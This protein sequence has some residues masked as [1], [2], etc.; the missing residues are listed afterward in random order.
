MIRQLSII[1]L[2]A[3]F[4]DIAPGYRIRKLT[5][6]ELSDKVSQMVGQTRDW[7]QGLVSVYQSYLQLLEKEVQGTWVSEHCLP[8]LKLDQRQNRTRGSLSTVHVHTPQAFNSF[9]LSNEH[10]EHPCGPAQPTFMGQGDILLLLLKIP[11]TYVRSVTNA[12]KLW[13]RSSEMTGQALRPS[14]LYAF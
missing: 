7:E 1:S 3:V 4:K 9:Q 2:S 8:R 12:S 5:E 13:S 6:K 14:K 10:H 11:K